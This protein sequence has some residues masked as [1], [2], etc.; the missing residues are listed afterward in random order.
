MTDS[1]K[2]VILSWSKLKIR[3]MLKKI[4]IAFYRIVEDL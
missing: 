3:K 2:G 1:C 4:K